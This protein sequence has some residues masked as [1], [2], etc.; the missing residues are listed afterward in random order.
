MPL[1]HLLTRPYFF[2][3]LFSLKILRSKTLTWL[4][5]LWVDP[6]KKMYFFFNVF[7]KKLKKY[8]SPYKYGE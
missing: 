8:C 6:A 3:G 7:I 4:L 5:D 2:R 1:G